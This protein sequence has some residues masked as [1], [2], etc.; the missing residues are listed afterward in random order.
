[1][2]RRAKRRERGRKSERRKEG[3]RIEIRNDK[4]TSWTG[5][6]RFWHSFSMPTWPTGLSIRRE[7]FGK[8]K[9]RLISKLN[10]VPHTPSTSFLLNSNQKRDRISQPGIFPL[11]CIVP[12]IYSLS[13]SPTLLFPY[14]YQPLPPLP[15]LR[16]LSTRVFRVYSSPLLHP[17]PMS[18][19]FLLPS[20]PH[21]YARSLPRRCSRHGHCFAIS[22]YSAS[23]GYAKQRAN[24]GPQTRSPTV[25]SSS[26]LQFPSPLPL[27]PSL[28]SFFLSFFPPSS[29]RLLPSSSLAPLLARAILS[30]SIHLVVFWSPR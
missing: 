5:K 25:S 23:P 30:P 15:S 28:L 10:A 7:G 14:L 16:R 21:P 3:R 6:K 2:K 22:A 18:A 29:H 27:F 12:T 4:D 24:N 26:V 8:R 13:P 19:F 9:R 20:P 11:V 17:P 1:M